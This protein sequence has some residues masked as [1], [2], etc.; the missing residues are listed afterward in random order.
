MSERISQRFTLNSSEN[1][2]VYTY[3]GRLWIHARNRVDDATFTTQMEER[4]TAQMTE[5]FMTQI[6][7]FTAQI[8]G[9]YG[10]DDGQ[11]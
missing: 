8:V 2:R 7:G 6:V 4:F 11:L 9:L 3:A 5:S 1:H 10:A